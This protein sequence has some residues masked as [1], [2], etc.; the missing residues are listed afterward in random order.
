MNFWEADLLVSMAHQ[1]QVDKLGEP[2][3][4]HVRAVAKG[5]QSFPLNIQIAGLLHDVV[6]DTR[7]TF[8]ELREIGVPEESVLMMQALTKGPGLT[9]KQQIEQ[10]IAGGY[11]ATLVKISDN[12]HN[13]HPDRLNRLP[14]ETRKRLQGKYKAAREQLWACAKREDIGVILRTV[15]KWLLPELAGSATRD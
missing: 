4:D 10:V 12:A 1:G 6:E 14:E 13:S 9:R 11:G 5:L 7:W 3:V 2:Y 8:D 15:N